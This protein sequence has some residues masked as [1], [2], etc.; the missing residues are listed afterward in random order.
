MPRRNRA[1][2]VRFSINGISCC[3]N[4]LISHPVFRKT[5]LELDLM[6]AALDAIKEIHGFD[7]FHLAGQSGGS[8]LVAALAGQRRDVG[9]IRR[10][11]LGIDR[12]RGGRIALGHKFPP[13][14]PQP[15]VLSAVLLLG[16]QRFFYAA[17]PARATNTTAATG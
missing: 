16:A 10:K 6:N 3:S 14:L 2:R 17:S 4:S 13:T 8:T 7:G 1:R 9:G 12:G 11:H 5:L 15:Q